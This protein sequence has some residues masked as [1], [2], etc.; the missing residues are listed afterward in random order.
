[1][2]VHRVVLV[3]VAFLDEKDAWQ[4]VKKY[5]TFIESLPKINR[6]TL[7]ALLQHLY[8][9]TLMHTRRDAR[10]RLTDKFKARTSWQEH[11]A[12]SHTGGVRSFLCIQWKFL[13]WV[14]DV[15]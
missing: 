6:S 13:V 7:E 8:R 2:F 5:S 14:Q 1:M 3:C 11:S 10:T 4:R 15:K 12:E 9:Y